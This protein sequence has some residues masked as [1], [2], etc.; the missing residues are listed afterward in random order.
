MFFRPKKAKY[1][2]ECTR[3]RGKSGAAGRADGVRWTRRRANFSNVRIKLV[4]FFNLFDQHFCIPTQRCKRGARNAENWKRAWYQR[5][6]FK[7]KEA[8]QPIHQ[9]LQTA[10]SYSGKERGSS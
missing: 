9:A 5:L 6:V 8:L 7:A 4:L 10:S 3:R 2:E 1:L